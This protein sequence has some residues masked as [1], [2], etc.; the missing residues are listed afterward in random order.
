MLR[1]LVVATVLAT[2]LAT[3]AALVEPTI[4]SAGTI[5]GDV[6]SM[7]PRTSL[8]SGHGGSMGVW[9]AGDVG[10]AY[11][12]GEIVADTF[13][14][15]DGDFGMSYHAIVG[16]RHQLSDDFVVLAD[17]GA[18]ITQEIDVQMAVLG[19]ESSV[20]TVALSP[21][22]A[23]R[24]QLAWVIGHSHGFQVG[25]ALESEARGGVHRN[26]AEKDTATGGIGLGLA[27]YIGR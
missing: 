15:R 23:L 26:H 13:T 7:A 8:D 14:A 10:P 24:A 19:G 25:L 2:V 1:R 3:V 27:F 6:V 16:T 17:A 22:A 20:D 4:A 5:G 12:G 11:V 9:M 18:G 21:S